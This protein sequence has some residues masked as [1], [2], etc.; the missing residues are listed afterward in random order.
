MK[1]LAEAKDQIAFL[2]TDQVEYAPSLLVPKK[3]SA[4]LA[5]NALARAAV[6]LRAAQPFTSATID[7]ALRAVADELGL[8]VKDFTHPVRVA[9]TGRSVGPPMFESLELLGRERAL[10]RIER[11]QRSLSGVTANA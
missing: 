9:V 8:P 3:Q 6:A 4:S 7:H 5:A 2:F 1:T 11:A 10:A